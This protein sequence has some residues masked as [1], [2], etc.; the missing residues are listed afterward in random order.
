MMIIKFYFLKFY[1]SLFFL[2]K[3]KR[4][5]E[6]QNGRKKEKDRTRERRRSGMK[7]S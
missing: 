7:E 3:S 1:H 2:Y 4:K 6:G 5:Q